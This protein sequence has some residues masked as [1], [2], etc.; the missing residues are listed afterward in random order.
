MAELHDEDNL[1]KRA[2]VFCT[3]FV[4]EFFSEQ[5]KLGLLK[6]FHK[7]DKLTIAQYSFVLFRQQVN[8]FANVHPF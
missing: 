6:L 1:N 8:F 7:N 5:K 2:E 3:T 4:K